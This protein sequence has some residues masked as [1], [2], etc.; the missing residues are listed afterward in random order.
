M[1]RDIKNYYFIIRGEIYTEFYDFNT[2]NPF[3]NNQFQT[4]QKH[5]KDIKS[6]GIR[7]GICILLFLSAPYVVSLALAIF[8]LG[9]K[10]EESLTLQYSTE[11][12]LSVIF[13]F[14]PFFAVYI[15]ANKKDKTAIAS[16]LEKPKSPL[17]FIFAIR[18][19]LMPCFAADYFS[20]IIASLFESIGV[21]LTSVPDFTVPTRGVN[22]FLFA[23]STIVPP[24]IIEEFTL[25]SVTMQP[26]RKYGDK[27]A[28]VMTAL[29]FGLMH[30]NAVQGIF[31]FI[32]G[33]VFGYIAIATGSVWVSVIVH[34]LNNGF[35]VLLRVLTETNEDLAN[36]VYSLV[37]SIVLVWGII[38]AVCF[39]VLC[40]RNKL[41]K[42]IPSLTVKDK[43][44]AFILNIPMVVA[45]II[46]ILYTLF[47]DFYG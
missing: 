19:G 7:I 43:T 26:L 46:M 28:I 45:L 21:T 47:G 37:I 6:H 11:M 2:G 41:R 20:S 44:S 5:K 1:E 16:S 15:L 18:F 36:K 14:L 32:A 24:A 25:R 4:K 3:I 30:R 35:S 39:F 42:G 12:L 33:V 31:A 22:L 17:T 27:F 40:K 38:S 23:F 10:Y 29:V 13:L 9:E 8:G 34:A